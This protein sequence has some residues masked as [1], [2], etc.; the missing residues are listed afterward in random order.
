LSCDK[1]LVIS[2][3]LF[4]NPVP[5]AWQTF[6]WTSLDLGELFDRRHI[7]GHEGA[8]RRT[9]GRF[10]ISSQQNRKAYAI[11]SPF[12]VEHAGDTQVTASKK[13]S[14]AMQEKGFFHV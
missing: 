11:I 9:P 10:A 13:V 12:V 7:Y 1:E 4:C 5:Y 3:P 8:D 2:N 6:R 14:F